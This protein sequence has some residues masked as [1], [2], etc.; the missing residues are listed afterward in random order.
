MITKDTAAQPRCGDHVLWSTYN[1]NMLASLID[2]LE[3]ELDAIA[4]DSVARMRRELASYRHVSDD[5]LL[6]LVRS[7]LAAGMRVARGLPADVSPMDAGRRRAEQG[8]AIDDMLNGW[9]LA[10]EETRTAARSA[11]A[12]L[13]LS[14]SV[15]LEFTDRVLTWSDE[16]MVSSAV[17]HRATELER[18]RR[19][20]HD[21]A[22]LVRGALLGTMSPGEIR[23]RAAAYSLD[24][25]TDYLAFRTP[26]T[27]DD[28][29]RRLERRLGVA[30]AAGPRT[31]LAALIDGDL[32]GFARRL[33]SDLGD[34]IVGVAPAGPLDQLIP[35]FA[36]AS[37]A[38]RTA[39]HLGRTGRQDFDGLGV[40]PAVLDDVEVGAP[41]RAAI[42]DPVIAN[43]TG[44]QAVLDTVARYLDLERRLDRTAEALH[45]H[46][47]TVRYRL[48]RFESLTGR[49]LVNTEHL[50]EVWWAL[51]L[52]G[53]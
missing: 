16:G 17:A 27:D 24:I 38:L 8:V 26:V 47:N 49:S 21:R 2:A 30:D 22:N 5:E 12:E 25:A 48:D 50:V 42:I 52:H 44:G 11:A 31:G 19:E 10:L 15:L 6:P 46:V 51:H 41:L 37:R 13:G 9:R 35:A 1:S 45:V 14:D 43:G 3:R 18:A 32:A 34:I 39:R 23:R 4:S 33:P 7:N 36:R 40:H 29:V 53:E 28:D 20:Q